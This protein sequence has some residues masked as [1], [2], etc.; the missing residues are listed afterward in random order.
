MS[1]SV[2]VSAPVV[3]VPVCRVRRGREGGREGGSERVSGRE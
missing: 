2:H 3:A 1:V